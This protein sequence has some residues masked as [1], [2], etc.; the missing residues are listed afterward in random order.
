MAAVNPVELQP[1]GLVELGLSMK[2]SMPDFWAVMGGSLGDKNKAICTAIGED[3][4]GVGTINVRVLLTLHRH[5][6]VEAIERHGGNGAWVNTVE[7]IT[8]ST[9]KVVRAT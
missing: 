3:L 7:S 6:V 8:G 2:S 4:M 5:I 1:V 9:F